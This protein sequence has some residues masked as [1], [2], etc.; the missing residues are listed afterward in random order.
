MNGGSTKHINR[1]EKK[2]ASTYYILRETATK[3]YNLSS[4][5]LIIF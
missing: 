1:K 4:S 3:K 2:L 5:D